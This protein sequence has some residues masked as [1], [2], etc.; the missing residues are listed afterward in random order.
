MIRCRLTAV[1]DQR[2]RHIHRQRGL[3]ADTAYYYTVEA[4]NAGGSSPASNEA[5]AWTLPAGPTGLTATVYAT[6]APP[7]TQIDLSW[8][9]PSGSIN[10]YYVY[11][12][13]SPGGESNTPLN[14]TA[15]SETTYIDTTASNG[16]TYYYDVKA[17]TPAG[18]SAA[19][20]EATALTSPNAPTR[21][22]ATDDAKNASTQIDLSWTL[23]S[24]AVTGYN[25]YRADLLAPIASLPPTATTF[26]DASCVP[27]DIYGYVVEAVN[28][29]GSSAPSIM[30]VAVTAPT[31]LTATD[32]AAN[33]S[34]QIDLN[35]AAAAAGPAFSYIVYRG[36]SPSAVNTPIYTGVSTSFDDFGLTPGTTYYY[37]VAVV[38]YDAATPLGPYATHPP[39]WS[40]R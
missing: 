21:L 27:G 7:A 13:T 1:A 9:A 11:R 19:S 35:W 31:D 25:V 28:G 2:R 5:T 4:V 37:D 8:T 16:T 6:A 36:T 20:N 12:G 26:S 30:A 32:D 29:T 10:G 33:P 24:G 38:Y 34:M 23:A 39:A 22:T 18:L 17:V 40:A 3:T 14:G 15:I